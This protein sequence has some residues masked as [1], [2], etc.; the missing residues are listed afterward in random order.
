MKKIYNLSSAKRFVLRLSVLATMLA[1][2]AGASAQQ[3]SLS[4][5]NATIQQAIETLQKEYGYSFSIRTSEVDVNKKISVSA[6]NED[7]KNVLE[8]VFDGEHVAFTIDGNIISVT[9]SAPEKKTG[10]TAATISGVVV[11]DQGTP[12]IGATVL[13]MN[14]VQGTT[15]GGGGEFTLRT[16]L[17][18]PTLQISFLGMKPKQVSVTDPSL[19]LFIEM[20]PDTSLID[21]VVIVGYGTQRRSMVTN[22]ISQFRPDENNMVSALS[23][24][25]M[26]NGRI[27]GVS[28]SNS[29]GNLGTMERVS[30]RGTG[31][32]NA[33]NEPLYVVDGI[34]LNNE[35]G[36]LY[37]FGEDLS[38]LSVLNLTDIESI[39]VLKDAAS[40]A[41][42]GSRATNGVILITTKQGREG[43]SEVRINYNFGIS[44]FPNAN[45]IRYADSATWVNMYN[46]GIDN[47]NRQN[48]FTSDNL[49]YVYHIR[50]PFQGLPDTDWLGL[51]TRLGMSHNVD[52]AFS[53]GTK[54]TKLY[55][56][57]NYG[58]QEGII[59][60]ND[61]TKINLKSNIS[62]QV[63][64]WLEVG[65][66][67]SGNYIQNNRVPGASLGSTILARAVEQ[68][69][70]DRPYKPNGDYYK[71]GT[72]ELSRHNP[73][74]ILSEQTSYVNNYRF[75]GAIFAQASITKKLKLRLSYNNDSGYT[76]DYI[77]YN[78]NHP[79]KENNGRIIEKN[80]FLMTN[81]VDTYA[82]YDDTWGDFGF[83]AMAGHSFLKTSSRGN[84]IDAQDFPSPSFDMVGS[85]AYF[86]SAS[87]GLSQYAMES[88]FGRV[89]LSY[90]ERYIINASLRADGSSKFAPK[91]RW[92]VF[93]SVSVGWNV[94]NEE[95]WNSAQ[96]SLKLRA[97]FGQTGNQDGIGNYQW[98]PLIGS[99]SNYGN[100]SGIAV[101]NKGNDSLTWE[102][103]DQYDVGFDLSFMGGKVNMIFD[104]YLKNTHKLL[105]NEYRPATTGQTQVLGNVGSMRNYGIEFTLNTHVN[106]GPVHWASSINI[107]HNKNKLTALSGDKD[108]FDLGS[109]HALKVGEEVGSFYLLRFDGI[110]Q[111]DGE[112]PAGE[113]GMGVRA[114]DA[115]LYDKDS[116]GT[117]NDSDRIL[118][119][120]PN[121]DFSGGWNN[122][123][124]YKNIN[125]N[126]F[127]TYSYGAD[128]YAQWLQ[129]P[130]R[131]GNY[132]AIL[133]N[134]A[135]NRWTGPG[136]TNQHFRS[137]YSYHG[138]NTRA[139][140]YYLK[141]ASFIKL[142]SVMLSYTLPQKWTKAM[143]MN[144]VR[145]YVQGENL[146]LISKYPGWD[147]E[148]ST[149]LDPR[150]AG[151]DNYGVPAP[152]IFKAGI[153]ITF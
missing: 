112:V 20:E 135:D 115:K 79:Y 62:H 61:V 103:A 25:N 32:L 28:T 7:I 140:T 119:G 43:H 82:T 149:S 129:G 19:R 138:N 71:G 150:Y 59:K 12:I 44:Q 126:I 122:S 141:D 63:T 124:T 73:V 17:P 54:K 128:I 134:A 120:S 37:S 1:G 27:A 9:K 91:H 36:S 64:K 86:A 55:I 118:V 132:Q 99:G 116:N 46:E 88:W 96:T 8:R 31:S 97:S 33:S 57:A 136:S 147:P 18:N 114:G 23:P 139:S 26:L 90:K 94:S 40:A 95:F 14:T 84:S 68:R 39:E 16:S 151:I 145:V 89:N 83:S 148:I 30:I 70:F 69:P 111:Y 66:N 133:Q 38:S 153:N 107:T 13:V 85:G 146:A 21:D 53:G 72:D 87:G 76:L 117:I 108:F 11:D 152:R 81:I 125:L 6:E 93:P 65:A 52:A 2:A 77:Y 101:G 67:M 56:A 144:S 58:Y 130:V 48:G 34:P 127:L 29:S 102:T 105:Y 131:L 143:R 80:R 110:Y 22:A 45:R 142:K 24:A 49:K 3:V 35:S 121:P 109:N 15:T 47:Y 51:I 100:K 74:Q 10:A 78:A 60:T 50:N 137:I 106:L 113:Y 75:L 98:Q 4:M 41:I 92:G 42:Y 5:R 123:F 104:T